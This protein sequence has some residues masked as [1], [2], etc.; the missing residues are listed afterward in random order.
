V[1]EIAY[2]PIILLRRLS[3]TR[4]IEGWTYRKH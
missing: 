2:S 3:G 4:S 1:R